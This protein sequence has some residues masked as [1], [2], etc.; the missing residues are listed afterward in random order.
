MSTPERGPVS[1]PLAVALTTV[2]FFAL[3]IAAFGVTSLLADAEVVSVPG[4]GSL[5]G[6][7]AVIVAGVSFAVLTAL[8]T[9]VARPTYRSTIACIVSVFVA[10]VAGLWLGALI[11]GADLARAGA[12]V[13]GFVTSPF[14]PVLVAATFV[15]AWTAVAL[16]RTRARRPR[17]RW[18]HDEDES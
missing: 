3:V 5:P 1:P 12:A 7:L 11:T 14:F 6:A 4:L 10:Y 15:C 2:G 18:E 16:V 9:R 8:A 17:W 13:G